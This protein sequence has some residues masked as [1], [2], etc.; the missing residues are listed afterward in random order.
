M[1]YKNAVLRTVLV[2]TAAFIIVGVTLGQNFTNSGTWVNNG[3]A[4]FNN[5]TNTGTATNG[6]TGTLRIRGTLDNQAVAA[7]FTAGGTV[8]YRGLNTAQTIEDNV[9]GGS[10]NNLMATRGGSKSLG[11]N[12][13]VSGQVTIDNLTGSGTVL[14]VGTNT[15]NLA[16]TGTVVNIV[17]GNLT[18]AVTGT[19]EYSG[20]N[21]TV[22]QISYGNLTF[23]TSAGTR[24]F[25]GGTTGIAGN[26]TI[27]AG[28]ADART[29]GSTIDYNGSGNQSVAQIDY[30][31]LSFSNAGT[32]TFAAGTT[33]IDGNFTIGGSA[34]ADARSFTTNIEFDGA[35]QNIA[36]VDYNS[37]TLNG[38]GVKTFLS[39]TTRVNDA[40]TITA[41]TPDLTTNTT[42]FEYDGSAAQTVRNIT[43]YDLFTSNT[44]VKTAAGNVTVANNLDNGGASNNATT[45]DMSTFTLS[46][47]GTID[48]SA[49]TIQFGGAGNGLAINSGTVEY[50]GTGVQTVALGDYARLTLSNGGANAKT[51]GVGTLNAS[52]VVT[53]N[54]GATLAIDG[55]LNAN[56]ATG[57]G[58]NNIGTL[59]V[60][61]TGVLNVTAD[62]AN[63]G[64]VT[65]SGIVQ[66][67]TD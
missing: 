67:G 63:S 22:A 4:S 64:S 24:T 40:F 5:F 35:A 31:N 37:L 3:T 49:A 9:A 14:A 61:G 27:S 16:G 55:T 47:T 21:A 26:F 13:T 60:N 66:V 1:S 25:L 2:G 62:L 41:G 18:S 34:V 17:T 59:N 46:V 15:L 6:A 38:A 56:L 39:G 7:N 44:G 50:N 28:T 43:Y 52:N 12:I 54:S 45:F 51:V 53:V 23:S 65:N 29:N 32:K 58:F 10:Y 48:N 57:T 11:G 36:A 19:I 33:R 30:R 8:D 20:G 42:T